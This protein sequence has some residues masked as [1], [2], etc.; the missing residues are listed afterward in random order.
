MDTDVNERWTVVSTAS[1]TMY[2]VSIN[3]M[4][5]KYYRFEEGSRYTFKTSNRSHQIVCLLRIT[6]FSKTNFIYRHTC[7][8]SYKE[9]KFPHAPLYSSFLHARNPAQTNPRVPFLW[10][11][12]HAKRFWYVS[13]SPITIPLNIF[14]CSQTLLWILTWIY[15]VANILVSL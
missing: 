11:I 1:H 10:T 4:N 9:I 12:L 2:S 5:F 8:R 15:D 3:L 14:C 13:I 7:I 6:W